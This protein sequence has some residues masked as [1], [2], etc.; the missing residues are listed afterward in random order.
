LLGTS[1]S[2]EKAEGLLRA[3]GIDYDGKTAVIPPYRV[4][5]MD[6][7]DVAEEVVN[8]Y[9]YSNLQPQPVELS[10]E[11][12]ARSFPL[13]EVFTQMGFQEVYTFFLGNG[14]V[15]ARYYGDVLKTTNA[16]TSEVNAL[17]PGLE[18]SLLG[19]EGKNK[20]KPLPH[21]FFELGHVYRGEEYIDL[22]FLV[23]N[24]KITV[25][26]LISVMKR[27]ALALG[28]ELEVSPYKTPFTIPELTFR[29]KLGD[30]EGY[31]GIVKPS[32]CEEFG[33]PHPIGLGVLH[34]VYRL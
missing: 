10:T 21:R 29:V 11:G 33:I 22:A 18:V 7:T 30:K 6:W 8:V 34:A 13:K 23:A 1:F 31:V 2:K 19:V 15:F 20:M 9:G 12:K 4:D 26:E 14:E 3:V 32:V 5:F 16:L 28:E 24:N 17:R 27:V 25:D